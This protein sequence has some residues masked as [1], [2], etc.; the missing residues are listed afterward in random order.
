MAVVVLFC[1]SWLIF[2]FAKIK[3][4]ANAILKL[5]VNISYFVSAPITL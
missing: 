4:K 2:F 5:I 3:A 1:I